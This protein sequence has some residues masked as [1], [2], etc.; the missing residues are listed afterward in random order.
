M[1]GLRPWTTYTLAVAGYNNAGTGILKSQR[2]RTI[3]SS[4]YTRPMVACC[5]FYC[6]VTWLFFLL[7]LL[8]V[9]V[10]LE[11]VIFSFLI[12]LYLLDKPTDK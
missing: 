12:A 1:T 10:L 2:V 5:Y 6:R 3:D 7:E 11:A 9:L 4:K 8:S